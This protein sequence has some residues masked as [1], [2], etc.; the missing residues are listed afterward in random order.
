[1]TT[2]KVKFADADL[3][4]E[5]FTSLNDEFYNL[6]APAEYFR[7]RLRTLLVLA[8]RADGVGRLIEEGIEYG[9][10]T[11]KAMDEQPEMTDEED[12]ARVERYVQ[13]EAQN[14]FHHT[15]ECL[16]RLVLAHLDM[17]GCPWLE[18]ARLKQP[19]AFASQ[20][21]R[22]V[23]HRETDWRERVGTMFLG[24][25]TPETSSGPRTQEGLDEVA[26]VYVELLAVL[27]RR[28][29][30]DSTLYNSTKHGLAVV[31]GPQSI[32]FQDEAT[33]SVFLGADGPAST[34]L[35][36][37]QDGAGGWCWEKATRWLNTPETLMLTE[38]AIQLIDTLWTMA[39]VRYTGVNEGRLHYWDRAK[40]ERLKSEARPLHPMKLFSVKLNYYLPARPLTGDSPGEI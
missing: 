36:I 22:F 34:F 6:A 40:W 4:T 12:A 25:P 31:T 7:F 14:L 23:D 30:D 21:A 39:R 24:G 33:G 35:Q 16:V 5:Q 18:L 8:G 9:P 19:G 38:L 3:A 29:Q 11:L 32:Q 26:G 28:L 17:P 1:M 13:S 15:A 20:L 27:A 2:K 10:I 37:V